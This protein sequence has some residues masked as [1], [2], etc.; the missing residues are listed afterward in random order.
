[1]YWKEGWR[2]ERHEFSVKIS[3]PYNLSILLEV[4]TGGKNMIFLLYNKFKQRGI[5][6]LGL[7]DMGDIFQVESFHR[8][9]KVDMWLIHEQ[10]QVES[11]RVDARKLTEVRV[12][13]PRSAWAGSWGTVSWPESKIRFRFYWKKWRCQEKN[14]ASHYGW[15]GSLLAIHVDV[16]FCTVELHKKP[17]AVA[18]AVNLELELLSLVSVWVSPLW[19][20]TQMI[21][22]IMSAVQKSYQI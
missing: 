16:P 10:D 12:S 1:M 22:F 7:G 3:H 4:Q 20:E 13:C 6:A 5:D 18:G 19:E 21:Y 15:E 17:A 14:D 11:F 8:E 2:Q 9:H